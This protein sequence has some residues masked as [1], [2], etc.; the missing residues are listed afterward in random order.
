[1]ATLQ[2]C[3]RMVQACPLPKVAVCMS[4]SVCSQ[5]ECCLQAIKDPATGRPQYWEPQYLFDS[6]S[7]LLNKTTSGCVPTEGPLPRT[8]PSGAGY[9]NNSDRMYGNPVP[10]V[11]NMQVGAALLARASVQTRQERMARLARPK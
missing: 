6:S 9:Y 8:T 3:M 4:R 5:M 11:N 10:C 7:P 1:M 2:S